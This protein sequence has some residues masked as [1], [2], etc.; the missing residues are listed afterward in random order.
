DNFQLYGGTGCGN[1]VEEGAD[2]V[3]DTACRRAAGYYTI[4]GLKRFNRRV[5]GWQAGWGELLEHR[6]C[7]AKSGVAQVADALG[8]G[9][10]RND[11]AAASSTDVGIR[12]FER[13]RAWARSDGGF[14]CNGC[15]DGGGDQLWEDGAGLSGRGVRVYVRGAGNPSRGGIRHRL[16]HG[17][18]LHREPPD[19]H[20]VVRWASA[21]VWSWNTGVGL[22]DFLCG[23][24]HAV[25]LARDQDVGAGERGTNGGD[26]CGGRGRICLGD[27]VHY[28]PS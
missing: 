12:R 5:P 9:F 16:E 7:R 1:R 4:D 17:D 27:P 28:G 13:S 23:S 14:D 2:C 19:L 3:E 18:G 21:R 10:V 6:K 22:E 8:F 11:R 20:G 25:E 26:E 15:H 24:V